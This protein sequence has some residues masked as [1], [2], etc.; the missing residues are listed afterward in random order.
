MFQKDVPNTLDDTIVF[1]L[2]LLEISQ[3][4]LVQLKDG[5]ERREHDRKVVS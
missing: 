5:S 2:A 3:N 1:L 4:L